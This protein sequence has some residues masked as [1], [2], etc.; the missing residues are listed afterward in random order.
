MDAEKI[1]A[2]FNLEGRT[3]ASGWHVTKRV[4]AKPNSTGGNFSVCYLAEKEGFE[5]FMKVLNVLSFLTG[6]GD[7]AVAMAE[8]SSAYL[9][10]RDIL[11]RCADRKM[12]KVSKLLCAEQEN[13][14]GFL[15]PNVMYMI[16]ERAD[17]DVRSHLNLSNKIDIIWKLRSLHNIAVGLKQLHYGGISHQDLKPSNVFVY[18]DRISKI[19]DLGRS[20]CSEILA[21]HSNSFFTGDCTYAPPETWYRYNLDNWNARAFAVDLYLLGSLIAY[22]LTGFT[23]NALISMVT[24]DTSVI[25]FTQGM[26]FQQAEPYLLEVYQDAF[27]QLKL[28]LK[29]A[30]IAEAEELYSLVKILCHPNP[31][32]RIF[33]RSQNFKG[34][35]YDLQFAISILNRIIRKSEIKIYN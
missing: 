30:Y 7:M 20:Q 26:T 28:I 24:E 12:S 10:E 2:A 33:H 21:P 25:Q 29:Q 23:M 16:L 5:G 22:Y 1:C 27:E 15:L 6:Q 11:S 32:K 13:I 19:G 31:E 4:V 35:K 18:S 3:L 8:M 17:G 34:N 9:F 14:S